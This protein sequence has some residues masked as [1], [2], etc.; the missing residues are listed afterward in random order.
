MDLDDEENQATREANGA[1][2]RKGNMEEDIKIL[3]ELRKKLGLYANRNKVKQ[4]IAIE[5]IL[6]EL[7]KK[8]RQ[9]IKLKNNN[10]NLL[11]KLRNR[12]KE[13]KKLTRYALYKKEITTLNKQLQQKI[14]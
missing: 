5:N 8:D 13:I 11:R 1:N 9:I 3:K 2:R 7:E 12:I 6:A 10:Q 14:R 4:G